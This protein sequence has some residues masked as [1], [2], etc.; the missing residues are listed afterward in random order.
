[1][2]RLV[3]THFELTQP[4]EEAPGC[5]HT[6][7]HQQDGADAM[8]NSFGVTGRETN[9]WA[10]LRLRLFLKYNVHTSQPTCF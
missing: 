3:R 7:K 6:H 9:I 8:K 2:Q 10:T 4:S 1:M 5:W